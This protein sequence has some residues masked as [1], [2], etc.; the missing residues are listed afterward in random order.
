MSAAIPTPVELVRAVS[1]TGQ[2]A[3]NIRARIL[4]GELRPGERL[5]EQQLAKA[6]GVGQN[7][8]REALFDL[9]HHGFVRRV[10]NRGTY[11][12]SLTFEEASKL[13]EVRG[14]LEALAIDLVRRRAAGEPI[15][16]VPLENLLE[17]MR[18][19]AH[20]GDR[21]AFYGADLSWHREL[22]R[23]AGNEHLYQLLEQVVVPL[24]AF[25][26][27]LYMRR[28]NAAES[29]L[30]A[31]DAH[32]KVLDGLK[33]TGGDAAVGAMRELVDLALKH[34]QG[35]IAQQE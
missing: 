17:E 8:V 15:D 29:F 18:Q 31:V 21:E 5:V 32:R 16:W 34:Q 28:D 9:A 3:A 26:I 20:A 12:T 4:R 35:L 25:F 6:L 14:A 10:V 27:M 2:I 22:W 1:L 23:L 13:A 33:A 30:E 11:V 7:A 19:A 24:F